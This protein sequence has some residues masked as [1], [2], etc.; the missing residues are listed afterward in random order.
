MNKNLIFAF[1]SVVIGCSPARKEVQVSDTTIVD[2]PILVDESILD[3]ATIEQREGDC[4]F[5]ND[6]HGLTLEW[7]KELNKKRFIWRADLDQALIPIGQDTIFISKGGCDHFGISVELKL[8]N[9][10]HSISDSTY[11]IQSALKLADDYNMEHYR[12]AIKEG[13]LR[14]AQNGEGTIWYEVDDDDVDDNL[15]YVGIEISFE[16]KSKRINLSEDYN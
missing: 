14:K 9:N 10:N 15:Y 5:N 12:K 6:Y 8:L 7:L 13:K 2:L 4:I 11:W 1:L 3:T 16:E